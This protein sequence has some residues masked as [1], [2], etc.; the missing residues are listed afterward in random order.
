[1][2]LR[3]MIVDDEPLALER[4]RLC[5]EGA[6]G[7][8]L[9]GE[10]S[11]GDMAA[12]KIAELAPDLV[13]LDVQMPGRSGMAVARALTQAPRPQVVFVTAFAEFAPEAFDLEA[14]DYIL[15]PVRYDRVQE[16]VRRAARRARAAAEPDAPAPPPARAPCA[17][18][19][20]MWIRRR[21]GLVRVGVDQILRIEAAR[22]YALI[23]TATRTDILRATMGDLEKRLDPAELLRVHRSAFVR[24]SSVV[25]VERNGRNL[26]R[27]HTEDGAAVDVGASY[28]RRVVAALRLSGAAD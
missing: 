25:R 15:K 3:A 20:E 19:A 9:V 23:H 16:A 26:M 13:M 1:M 27:L 10:A 17:Y 4:L 6:P 2:S 22:D 11:D 7:V 18:D 12:R 28:A 21:E 14:A 24:P 5:L 8:E